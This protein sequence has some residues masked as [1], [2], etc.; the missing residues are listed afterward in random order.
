MEYVSTPP[1]TIHL[2]GTYSN[3]QCL[4]CHA[5][6]RDFEANLKHMAPMDSLATNQISCISS[7][8]H[9]TIHNASEVAHLKMWTEGGASTPLAS[10]SVTPTPAKGKAAATAKLSKAPAR[11]SAGD[12]TTAQGRDIYDSQHCSAC[13][14][15]NGGGGSGPALAHNASHYPPAQSTAVLK[16]PT[17]KMKAAG[18]VPLSVN[19]ADMKALVSYLTSLGRTSAVSGATLPSVGS[20]SP[21]PAKSEPVPPAGPSKVS[22]GDS[23]SN[24]TP[25][26]GKDIYDSQHCSGCHGEN[27]GGGSGPALTHTASRYPPAQLTAVLKAPTAKM[28]AAGMVPLTVNDADMRA[29]VSYISSLR[30]T[31][32]ASAATPPS[33]GP[34]SPASAAAEPAATAAPSKARAGNSAGDAIAARGK[35]IFDSQGCSGCH[36]ETGGGGAGP[37]VARLSS[38]YSPAQMAAVLTGLTAVLKAPTAKMK[39]AGMVPLTVDDADMKALVTYVSILGGASEALAAASSV[40]GSSSVAPATVGPAVAASPSKP[41]SKGKSI[42]RWTSVFLPYPHGTPATAEPATATGP[43]KAPA[44]S[45]AGEA[46]TAQER[47]IYDSQHCSAC[48]GENGSGGSG[49]A[50]T[51]TASQYS[52]AQLTAVLKAPNAKMKAAGMVPLTVTDAEMKALVSYVI[53]LEATSV[54]SVARTPGPGSSSSAPVKA[55]RVATTGPPHLP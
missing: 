17:A 33:A 27:G 12:A 30:G 54:A 14:G 13:H 25:A 34:S 42:L 9:A 7:G 15:E 26:Q 23:A 41:E 45:S 51:H 40:R 3:L 4:R 46:S 50:L 2:D 6:T 39:A 10:E 1:K 47:A 11:S 35:S 16:A 19:A 29:L 36:G 32:A 20:S 49:P 37:A 55:Q 8:C 22:T 43:S 53:S 5:G 21:L 48:H 24:A 31:P 52:P 28:K 38:Q 18:M 44:G